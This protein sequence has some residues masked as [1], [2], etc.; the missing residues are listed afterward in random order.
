MSDETPKKVTVPGTADHVTGGA[1]AANAFGRKLLQGYVPNFASDEAAEAWL[2]DG[3]KPLPE[4]GSG[5]GGAYTMA[6][7]R[8]KKRRV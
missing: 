6:D 2:K 3:Q 7:V 1:E 5:E 8:P 4:E